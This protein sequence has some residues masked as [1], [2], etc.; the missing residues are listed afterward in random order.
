MSVNINVI[1]RLGADAEV[2]ESAKG[3]FV[4]FRLATD[5]WMP[6]TKSNETVWFRVSD[7]SNRTLSI[8]EHLKKGR[9]VHVSGTELCSIFTDKLNIVI[10]DLFAGAGKFICVFFLAA[11][12]HIAII[13]YAAGC[14]YSSGVIQGSCFGKCSGVIQGSC[15]GNTW[16]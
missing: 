10:R 7:F 4:T 2:K 6:Q 5:V 13:T 11:F 16:K 9:Q 8:A 12:C 15:F 3:K 1:G 14:C